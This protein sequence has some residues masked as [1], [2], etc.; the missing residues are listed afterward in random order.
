M[1]Q[2]LDPRRKV[3]RKRHRGFEKHSAMGAARPRRSAV[4]AKPG[5]RLD[6]FAYAVD[7]IGD[8]QLAAA[9]VD[10]DL[11]PFAS[12]QD[13]TLDRRSVVS[14]IHVIAWS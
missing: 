11:A 3:G 4:E 13:L 6:E 10:R 5:N 14:A 12:A 1:M 2:S 8:P 9:Q 7:E